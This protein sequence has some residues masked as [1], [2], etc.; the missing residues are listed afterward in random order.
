MKENIKV[1]ITLI[2]NLAGVVLG[3]WLVIA[4]IGSIMNYLD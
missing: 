4:I 3:M 2:L 1:L